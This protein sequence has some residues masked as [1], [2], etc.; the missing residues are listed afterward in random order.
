MRLTTDRHKALRS[1]SETAEV[2]YLLPQLC[3]PY[4]NTAIMFGMEKQE[5]CHG[6]A[7]RWQKHFEDM[8][9]CFDKIHERDGWTDR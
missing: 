7:T 3:G 9:T 4:H 2:R 6:V 8:F 5:R 1:P